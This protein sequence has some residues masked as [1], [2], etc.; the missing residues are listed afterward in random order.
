MI[1]AN[2]ITRKSSL[3]WWQMTWGLPGM[4]YNAE[5][6]FSCLLSSRIHTAKHKRKHHQSCSSLSGGCQEAKMVL[7]LVSL[8]LGVLQSLWGK[9]LIMDGMCHI[10]LS[11]NRTLKYDFAM[12]YTSKYIN[13][14]PI[15]WE[16]QGVSDWSTS[17][18]GAARFIR[19]T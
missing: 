9:C 6:P 15:L 7:N 13:E 17:T 19:Q 3:K 11:L 16:V 18:S 4:W 10:Y 1:A 12:H 14:H 2:L 8:C 5:N